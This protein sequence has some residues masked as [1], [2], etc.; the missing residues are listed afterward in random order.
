MSAP[1]FPDD[2]LF[3]Q[4]FLSCCG[5]YAGALDGNYGAKTA[6]AEQA[7]DGEADR[8]ATKHGTFDPRSE[9]NLRSLQIK[10][11]PLARQSLAALLAAGVATKILSGTRTYAQQD[12]L[13]RQGRNSN[14]GNIVTNAKGGQSWHNFGLAWDIGL[15][16]NGASLTKSAPYQ[17]AASIAKIAGLEWGG[18]WTSF[19]DMPHYQL[20]TGGKP[21]SAARAQFEKGGRG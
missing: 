13:Y 9:T 15:F 18:D 5:L 7:F 16:Q 11:Q 3:L 21:V 12:A 8:I 19:Q 14:P 1:L 10:A 20:A 17:A 2:I 4:R 6:A